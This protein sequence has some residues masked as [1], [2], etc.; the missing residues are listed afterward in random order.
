MS[1]NLDQD[2]LGGR[3][4]LLW[5]VVTDWESVG[6]NYEDDRDTGPVLQAHMP[7]E[8]SENLSNKPNGPMGFPQRAC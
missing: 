4:V 8:S 7:Y 1:P 5:H 6:D 3:V 2:D